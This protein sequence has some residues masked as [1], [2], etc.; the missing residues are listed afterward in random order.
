MYERD[1]ELLDPPGGNEFKVTVLARG[2]LAVKEDPFLS[3][4]NPVIES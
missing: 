4:C 3:P 2:T 1:D